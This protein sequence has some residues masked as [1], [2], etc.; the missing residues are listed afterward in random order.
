MARYNEILVG[1]Y[2]RFIQKL[3]GMKGDAS[4]FQLST[5]LQV[6][7]GMFN[8]VENRYLESWDRFGIRFF[9]AGGGAGNASKVRFRNPAG[10]NV[11]VVF[12]KLL[13]AV[14]TGAAS[15]PVLSNGVAAADLAT[16]FVT[17]TSRLDPRGR[18]SPS[19]SLSTDNA[20]GVANLA[21]VLSALALTGPIQYDYIL[22][23]DQEIPILPGDA[24][25]VINNTLN[26]QIDISVMWRERFLEESERT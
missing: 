25:Q 14:S 5:E 6:A 20:S 10:S 15:V 13:F 23:E 18:A 26:T 9:V 4:L 3:M 22:F 24:L 16:P 19:V 8:G 1:R 2:N 12:E 21:N 11:M 7:L 17:T